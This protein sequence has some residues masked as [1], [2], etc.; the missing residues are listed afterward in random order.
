MVDI[1]IFKYLK[2]KKKNLKWYKE[3][4]HSLKKCFLHLTSCPLCHGFLIQLWKTV[5]L[6]TTS[7]WGRG[8][9][10]LWFGCMWRWRGCWIKYHHR[11]CSGWITSWDRCIAVVPLMMIYH[12]SQKAN[13]YKCTN[14]SPDDKYCKILKSLIY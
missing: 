2:K 7:F 9:H 11:Y 6:I 10:R 8:W 13:T 12:I 3:Y 5:F 4:S 14:D 1:I